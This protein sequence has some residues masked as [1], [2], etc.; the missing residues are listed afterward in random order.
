MWVM[1]VYI[2]KNSE[3]DSLVYGKQQQL[4][5]A[6]FWAPFCPY[7][8]AFKLLFKSAPPKDKDIDFVKVNIEQMPFIASKKYGMQGISV[9]KFFC[10]G[11]GIGKIVGYIPKDNFK[12]DIDNMAISTPPSC[13]ANLSSVKPSSSNTISMLKGREAE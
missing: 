10:E 13:L 6:D 1:S 2:S 4:I 11:R 7:C 5:A 8:S 9:V 3:W 12:K